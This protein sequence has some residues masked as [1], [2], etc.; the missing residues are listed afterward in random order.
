[1]ERQINNDS[2]VRELWNSIT[3]RSPEDGSER[4]SETSVLIRATRYEVP[5]S[6]LKSK[7]IIHVTAVTTKN[8]VFGEMKT[9]FIPH[10][11]HITSPV[12]STA[13]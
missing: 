3:L 2:K 12:Q 9:Q 1:M 6:D 4:F 13:G 5:E 10:R 7:S 11:N 8:A